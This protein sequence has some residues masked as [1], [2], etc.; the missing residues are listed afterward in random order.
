MTKA[1]AKKLSEA[2]DMAVEDP[3][4][5]CNAGCFCN[6]TIRKNGIDLNVCMSRVKD[7]ERGMM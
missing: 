2:Y 1:E 4:L 3:R 5:I 6:S 7:K